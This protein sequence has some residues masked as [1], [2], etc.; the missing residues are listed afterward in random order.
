MLGKIYHYIFY[1]NFLININGHSIVGNNIRYKSPPISI[2]IIDFH[3]NTPQIIGSK[4]NNMIKQ[5]LFKNQV[6]EENINNE[7][8]EER[9]TDE[10]SEERI[11][12]NE[13]KTMYLE[14]YNI[15]LK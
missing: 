5:P 10:M 1:I 15:E 4:S 8:S 11:T 2:D 14:Q 3:K 9:I 7:I 12:M 13:N 6:S